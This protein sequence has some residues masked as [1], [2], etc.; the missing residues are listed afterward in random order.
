AGRD[1]AVSQ[2][3]ILLDLSG[4]TALFPAHELRAGYLRAHPGDAV[5]VQRAIAEAAALIGTFDK[6]RYIAFDAALCAHQR[7]GKTGCTRCLDLCPTGA[8]TPNGNAVAIS[9]EICAGC[10][11][12]A[13]VCPTGAAS[14][15]LPPADALMRRLRTLMTTYTRAG[16]R[17]GIILLHDEDHGRALIDML[18]RHGEGLPA[19]VLPVCVNEVTQTGIETVAAALAFGARA[20]R[21]L[22]RAR[23]KH[24]IAAAQ[25]T[26]ALAQALAQALGYGADAIGL[27]QID[28]P[29]ALRD[30]LLALAPSTMVRTASTFLPLGDKRSVMKQALRALHEAAPQPVDVIALPAQAPFGAVNVRV[31]GCTLC[32]ACVSAC[33]TSALG[34]NPD[35]PQLTFRE[36]ACVQCGLCAATC[37]EKVI[38]LE[39]RMNFAALNALPVIVKEE[40]PFH[41]IAC[42]KP[43]GTKSTI[44]RVIAKLQGSHWMFS[45]TDS[46]RI[47]MLK[48]CDDC[49]VGAVTRSRVDPYAS[50]PRPAVRTTDDYLRERDL[51]KRKEEG[52]A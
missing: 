1:G 16:G 29:D 38:S 47:E 7:S 46:D 45:G 26:V 27:L 18:A 52:N 48:M 20:V 28:D 19:H 4:G 9:A 23:P 34:D 50:A 8:I 33:P 6:P 30:E 25:R 32:L 39:P 12:C 43:F 2:A 17:D 21:I 35:K 13:A 10:G 36:D 11:S 14:Y 51:L 24:D 40:E 3:D 44:E 41:C 15:A 37:P 49:R 31:D 5:A 42:A 22:T